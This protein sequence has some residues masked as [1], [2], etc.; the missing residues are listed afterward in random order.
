MRIQ[1]KIL[2][3]TVILSNLVVEA[4]YEEHLTYKLGI[5]THTW[6]DL[7]QGLSKFEMVK[8]HLVGSTATVVGDMVTVVCSGYPLHSIVGGAENGYEG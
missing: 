3:K 8:L 1:E 7:H 4:I 2:I 6:G 5:H